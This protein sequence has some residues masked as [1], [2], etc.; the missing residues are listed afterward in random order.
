MKYWSEALLVFKQL[1]EKE[2]VARLYR[3]TANVLWSSQGDTEKAKTH[4]D[5]ALKILEKEPENAELASLFDD[6]ARLYLRTADVT[7][8]RSWT[9][10][11]IELAEKINACEVIASSY[12]N[13]GDAL[14]LTED[15]KKA[16]EYYRRALKIALDNNYTETAIRADSSLSTLLPSLELGAV[17]NEK[18]FEL[19]EKAYELAKKGRRCSLGFFH[20]QRFGRCILGHGKHGQSDAI[21]GRISCTREEDSKYH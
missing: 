7:E 16:A 21:G 15:M 9:E 12:S 18:S 2:A 10:K 1:N 11:A 8:A 4:Y 19:L 6:M 3:K 5:E 13:L 14:S 17:V 20:G